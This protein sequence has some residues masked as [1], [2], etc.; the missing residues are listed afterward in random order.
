MNRSA[1]VVFFL[2]GLLS[3]G[4]TGCPDCGSDLDQYNNSN[5]ICVVDGECDR[6]AGENEITC[7]EDCVVSCSL[8][9]ITGHVLEV[10]VKE[11]QIPD[12]RVEF[13][14]T[15]V[16]LDGDGDIEN[17]LG[18]LLRLFSSAV[19]I[20]DEVNRRIREGDL[21]YLGRLHADRLHNDEVVLAQFFAGIIP[22]TSSTPMFQGN[23]ELAIDPDL[24]Q[25]RFFFGDIVSGDLRVGPTELPF[26]LPLPGGVSVDVTLYRAQIRGNILVAGWSN[27]MVGGGVDRGEVET[28]I[29]PALVEFINDVIQADPSGDGAITM[30]SMFDA[31]CVTTIEG[32][33]STVNG[34]G[35]C[36]DREVPAV[37]TETELK[38]NLLTSGALAPDIDIDGDRQPDLLSLGFNIVEAVP[39]SI[40][41]N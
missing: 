21:L 12:S 15:G 13:P 39:C 5:L 19:D 25:S 16:D 28:V 29:V 10:V 33:E 2:V 36:S 26:V 22:T 9:D 1:I 34:L 17:K 8:G 27:V 41:S 37:I 35:E 30:A 11:V 32:C 24:D 31:K 18:V 20:N 23:D 38:C 3:P 14:Q 7:P 4:L 6:S 40:V